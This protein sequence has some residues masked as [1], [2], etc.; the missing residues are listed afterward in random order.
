MVNTYAANSTCSKERFHVHRVNSPVHKF[1]KPNNS[2]E[3]KMRWSLKYWF[4]IRKPSFA[5]YRTHPYC[6]ILYLDRVHGKIKMALGNAWITWR[7]NKQFCKHI[8]QMKEPLDFT[9][10]RISMQKKQTWA[11]LVQQHCSWFIYFLW[12]SF[13]QIIQVE[14]SYCSPN[15]PVGVPEKG[16]I[17]IKG[18]SDSRSRE[19]LWKPGGKSPGSVV[20]THKISR[21][22]NWNEQVLSEDEPWMGILHLTQKISILILMGN[23]MLP[24]LNLQGIGWESFLGKLLNIGAL[25][26][27]D[28]SSASRTSIRQFEEH[29]IT[30]TDSCEELHIF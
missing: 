22:G 7:L 15:S 2:D 17:I 6:V 28:L 9:V 18:N 8:L 5:V 11:L 4:K 12:M 25:V 10:P 24:L 26:I 14:V 16:L 1:D 30:S 20:N 27:S 19:S 3:K 29:Y 21:L 13:C 23:S